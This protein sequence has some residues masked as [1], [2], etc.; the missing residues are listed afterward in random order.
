MAGQHNKHVCIVNE[1]NTKR[2]PRPLK[3]GVP[4]IS[5]RD[6]YIADNSSLYT[7]L[8]KM[9][10][11]RKEN[12]VV[13]PADL[14]YS[15]RLTNNKAVKRDLTQLEIRQNNKSLTRNLRERGV[16]VN[17]LSALFSKSPIKSTKRKK[18][19]TSR[20]KAVRLPLIRLD[21]VV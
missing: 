19:S 21:N 18:H 12:S 20:K 17:S 15:W 10:S 14:E 1:I 11:D 5:P 2:L 4:H 8:M 7:K 9:P 16:A 3:L 6:S 13:S